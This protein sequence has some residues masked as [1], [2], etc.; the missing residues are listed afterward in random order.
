MKLSYKVL[1]LASFTKD[2]L[3]S[4][5]SWHGHHE[6]YT[7]KERWFKVNSSYNHGIEEE[8]NFS[9]NMQYL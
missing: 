3:G 6:E 8:E 1:L 4:N 7:R 2:I 9:Y 5:T